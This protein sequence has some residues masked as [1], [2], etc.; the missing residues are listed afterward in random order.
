MG[1]GRRRQLGGVDRLST[2]PPDSAQTSEGRSTSSGRW[3]VRLV[4]PATARRLSIG[5]YT[6]KA[7]AE[8][9]FA[10][11]LSAQARNGWVAPAEGRITL[12]DY[13]NGWL[14]SRLTS[15]GEPLRLRVRDLYEGLLRLHILPT[16]GQAPLGRLTTAT[17]RR[18][19]AKLLTDGPGISTTAKSYRLLRA[20][21]NTAVEDGHLVVNP[22]S[23]KGAGVEPCEE[24]TIPDISQVYR[25]A[26]TVAPRYRVLVLLAAF[27]G[28]RR[29]ELFGL[30]RADIDI[31]HRRLDVRVQRQERR[32][33]EQLIGP[34]KTAAGRRSLTLPTEL[35]P[36]LEAHLALWVA[37]HADAIIF[38][39]EKGGPVRPGV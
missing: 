2:W 13:A 14:T 17:L 28:L 5:T 33:G 18:W 1:R 37:P 15:R 26:D 7:E 32:T 21:L 4:D 11:A 19:H 6:T 34:P 31:L 16:L 9:A 27:G 22:C 25:L 8:R 3:R 30:T 10:N 39:G 23:I 12:S 29:G 24:R 35:V 38:V 36:E 20:M